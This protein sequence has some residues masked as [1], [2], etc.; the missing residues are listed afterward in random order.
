[1]SP[2]D[3][4]R[5]RPEAT[6]PAP[7][8]PSA[9]RATVAERVVARTAGVLS[10]GHSRRR[11]LARTA[12]VGSALAVNP[13]TYLLKP[14]T[15][16]GAV[17]GTCSDGWTAFCCTIN[18]GS[19]SC[20]PAT[21]V[22]GWWK[23]DGSAYCGGG[24]RYIIDC[25]A[26]CPTQC[27]CRCAGAAC[28]GRRTCCNQFRYG[29]CNQQISC[30]GPVACRVA[31]CITP[32]TYDPACST[33]TLTDN[34][35]A[36]HGAACLTNQA[37]TPIARKYQ[38]L[39]G[40]GGILG[41]ETQTERATP[42]GTGRY[43]VY[44][45]GRIYDSP[46]TNPQEIHGS[47]LDLWLAAGATGSAYGYPTTDVS[48]AAGSV[49]YSRFQEGAIYRFTDGK[50]YGVPQP[51]YS[52]Y[53]AYGGLSTSGALGYPTSPIRRSGDDRSLY[54]N[55][56]KGRI[57]R[58]GS[59]TAEIHGDI[60]TKH[61][62]L[63][64]IYGPLGHVQSSVGTLAD[65]R[66]KASIFEHGGVIYYTAATGA[67]GVWGEVLSAY[68]DHGGPT[69]DLG[70]PTSDRGDVG[71]GRGVRVTT[72][73]GGVYWTSS[74][75]AHVVPPA[76]F[77]RWTGGPSGAFGYPTGDP[78]RLPGDGVRQTFEGGTI[79]ASSPYVPFVKATYAD[80]L[81][82]APTADEV[83]WSASALARGTTTKP[84]YVRGLSS[85]DEYVSA[86]VQSF[87]QDTLGRP[88]SERD[89]AWW[90]DRIQAGMSVAKVAAFFFSSPEYYEIAGGT[91]RTWLA[92]VFTAM[93][94]R[95]ATSGDLDY[96]EEQVASRG[97]SRVAQILYQANES[98]VVR[99]QRIYQ[100]LLGRA[101]SSED[102]SYWSSRIATQGDLALA[103]TI[104]SMQEYFDRC[105]TRF[106]S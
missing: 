29:Q 77:S 20:P 89:V 1:M 58:R 10:G 2:L 60:F 28:D 81:D 94:G 57:Y 24:P 8:A 4:V 91:P 17:C 56:Q 35:T 37:D 47:I 41:R 15:A 32:W 73:H 33:R 62:A 79:T 66:G 93:F 6:P 45:N 100:A 26:T 95:S 21:F 74:T 75:G 7:S 86:L 9:P 36:D 3:L 102:A 31:I 72:E 63:D 38:A 59:I 105:Q 96:W 43:A 48:T 34:R 71:D 92:D 106:P 98:R 25:N 85:S 19:N 55:F 23:A 51:Y 54:I 80:F 18:N 13:V 78:Q 65:G 67:H 88:G 40:A 39:G 87:Y 14:G 76:I 103:S 44:E 83:D 5:R 61:E 101:A 99:V 50:T 30:Y 49:R 16:Y 68:I 22:A 90:A 64:G 82:R 42:D 12:V 46:S 69:S 70:Y 84:T 104:A 11:F 27:S 97:R 53:Q 52:V